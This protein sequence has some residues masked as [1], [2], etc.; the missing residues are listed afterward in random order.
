MSPVCGHTLATVTATRHRLAPDR[1]IG[2][3]LTPEDRTAA[4]VLATATA[5][6]LVFEYW[7]RPGFYL[8]SGLRDRVASMDGG[9]F[10]DLADALGY[11]WWGLSSML[12]RVLVPLGIGVW[13]LHLRP[14]DLG[15]RLVG[16]GRHLP[17]YGI[18][19]LVMLP[20]LVWVSGFQSFGT[21]YPFYERAVEGG[22]G[23]WVYWAGYA[24]Q[25]V[26]VEAF[27]RGYLTFGLAPRFGWLA[28]P[29]MTVPY[30]MIHFAK[31]MPEAVAAIGA[32]LL[33]GTMALRSRSWVPGVFLHVA[34]ALTLDILV[35][36]RAG[37]ID[38]I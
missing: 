30:T 26:G 33:L 31:P 36:A 14:A 7:G 23:L 29:I 35:M 27:F 4:I 34:V 21:F 16:I 28:V 3:E 12:W 8:S 32:G 11:V 38:L 17:A 24:L 15:Y 25:F 18:A 13:V 20:L 6:L 1:L 19:Y 22:A 9:R 5:L 2:A 37:A 10:A